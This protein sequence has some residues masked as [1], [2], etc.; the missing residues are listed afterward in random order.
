MKRV[1]DELFFRSGK[2]PELHPLVEAAEFV[3]KKRKQRRKS[4]TVDGELANC[5]LHI[6]SAQSR[7]LL[8]VEMYIMRNYSYSFICCC[9]LALVALAQSAPT[10]SFKQNMDQVM[11]QWNCN[12][13]KPRLVY[14]G[15]SI[16]N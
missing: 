14:L 6:Y 7:L 3:N 2:N 12:K 13:P 10:V 11:K 15:K 8:S 16:I 9:L 4:L 1:A 5:S